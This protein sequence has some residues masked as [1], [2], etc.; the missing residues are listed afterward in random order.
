MD[1]PDPL[2]A[3]GTQDKQNTK[4]NTENTTE[5]QHDSILI[6]CSRRESISCIL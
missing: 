5:K 1:N 3:L 2:A 6:K 4:D